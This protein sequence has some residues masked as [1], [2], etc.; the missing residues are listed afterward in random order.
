MQ[1]LLIE[2]DALLGQAI[3]MA[4]A[5]WSHTSV[6]VRDGQA[7][8]PAARSLVTRK[9]SFDSKPLIVSSWAQICPI[10]RDPSC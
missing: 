10:S 6:W 8:L 5:R 9:K 1:V 7:A 2:D 3:E 4:L